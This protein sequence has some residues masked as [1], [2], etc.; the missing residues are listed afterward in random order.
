VETV[1]V[2]AAIVQESTVVVQTVGPANWSVPQYGVLILWTNL[3][4]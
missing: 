2:E 1:I 3:F 4:L